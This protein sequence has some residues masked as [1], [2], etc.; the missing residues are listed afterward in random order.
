MAFCRQGR[1]PSQVG[2][3]NESVRRNQKASENVGSQVRLF[4]ARSWSVDE[5]DVDAVA[6]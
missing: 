1:R 4:G 6:D 3:R 2:R 5:F